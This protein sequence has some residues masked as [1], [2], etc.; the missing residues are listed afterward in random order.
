[1]VEIDISLMV[2]AV[3]GSVLVVVV[4]TAQ[5][6]RQTLHGVA[7]PFRDNVRYT[8]SSSLSFLFVL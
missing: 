3:S 7:F 1:M 4:A 6:I 5:A 8:F 2:V